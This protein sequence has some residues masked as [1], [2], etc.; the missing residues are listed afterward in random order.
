MEQVTVTIDAN[1]LKAIVDI[2]Y[3]PPPSCILDSLTLGLQPKLAKC[4]LQEV[5][6]QNMQKETYK[7]CSMIIKI[8]TDTRQWLLVVQIIYFYNCCY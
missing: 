1:G 3:L 7:T 8:P 2:Y 6:I 5:N 4:K